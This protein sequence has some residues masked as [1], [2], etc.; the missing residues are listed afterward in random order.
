V[1]SYFSG[2]FVE[3]NPSTFGTQDSVHTLACA[4][5]LL[6]T[7]IYAGIRNGQRMT[8]SEFIENL[9]G[10]NEGGDFPRDVL[11][12]LYHSIRSQPLVSPQ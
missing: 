1:L 3:R 9:S 6:N 10:L 2:R 5:M 4:L 11:K 7:D 12:Q 8:C